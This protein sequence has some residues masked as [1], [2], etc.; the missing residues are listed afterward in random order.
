MSPFGGPPG[1]SPGGR[2]LH[3]PDTV[4]GV[5]LGGRPCKNGTRLMP[6]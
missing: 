1:R 4:I 3:S 2:L 6:G 5:G